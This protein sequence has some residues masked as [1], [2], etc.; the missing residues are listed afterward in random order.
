MI[1]NDVYGTSNGSDNNNQVLNLPND[2]SPLLLTSSGG[3]PRPPR[4]QL[5]RTRATT[6]DVQSTTRMLLYHLLECFNLTLLF[7]GFVQLASL[8]PRSLM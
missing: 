4:S 6:G 2:D 8:L 3:P 5:A 7:V 1:V